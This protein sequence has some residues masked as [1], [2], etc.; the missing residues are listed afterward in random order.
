MD[1]GVVDSVAVVLAAAG[2]ILAGLGVIPRMEDSRS[3]NLMDRIELLLELHKS[4]P[5][6]SF[7]LFALGYEFHKRGQFEDA[8]HWYQS[9][10]SSTPEYTG[11]YYHLGKLYAEIGHKQKAVQTFKRGIEVCAKLRES[12]DQGELQQALIELEDE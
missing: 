9:I 7:T 6:D 12:K 1:L 11:V 8:L 4:D 5:G 2:R 3:L 10:L